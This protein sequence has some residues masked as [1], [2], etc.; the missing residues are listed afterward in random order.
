MP[1]STRDI[2]IRGITEGG[3]FDDPIVH[4]AVSTQRPFVDPEVKR[5]LDVPGLIV[6]ER[7]NKD[8]YMPHYSGTDRSLQ[9][10][11]SYL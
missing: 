6:N 7:I 5:L 10:L 1:S 3:T 9:T 2:S 11:C 8:E 4:S